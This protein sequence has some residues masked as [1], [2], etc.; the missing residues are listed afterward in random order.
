MED[1]NFSSNLAAWEE[2]KEYKEKVLKLKEDLKRAGQQ[3]ALRA[4]IQEEKM[5]A[6]H[7]CAR[8]KIVFCVVRR[9]CGGWQGAQGREVRVGVSPLGPYSINGIL[10]NIAK[11]SPSP[12]IKA[13][14]HFEAP[15]CDLA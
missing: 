7:E 15:S 10:W 12:V 6:R 9:Y 4:E 1:Q 8:C 5:K 2:N 14:R 13:T 11:I 3:R